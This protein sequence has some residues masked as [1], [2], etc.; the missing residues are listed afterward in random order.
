MIS[1]KSKLNKLR[2][3]IDTLIGDTNNYGHSEVRKNNSQTMVLSM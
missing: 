1:K 3:F 2:Y